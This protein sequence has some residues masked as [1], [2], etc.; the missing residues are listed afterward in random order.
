MVPL[1]YL[2]KILLH[3]RRTGL[4][5]AKRGYLGGF[6]LARPADETT[7]FDIIEAVE[8][9]ALESKCFYRT[10]P[11]SELGVCFV[12]EFWSDLCTRVETFLRETSV[13]TLPAP[14]WPDRL[15]LIGSPRSASPRGSGP[16]FAP[17]TSD[18]TSQPSG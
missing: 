6:R 13:A 2:Q 8:P 10:D 9:R 11:C 17:P 14:D 1:P 3:L 5:E 15:T 4:V 16:G 7:L 12:H 18:D